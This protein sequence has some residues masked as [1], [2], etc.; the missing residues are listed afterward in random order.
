MFVN[1]KNKMKCQRGFTL[2]ELLVVIAIIGVLAAIAVPKYVNSIASANT[3]KVQADLS[4]IDTASQL[5][6]SN[7]GGAVPANIAALVPTYLAVAPTP[8]TGNYIIGGA[9]KNAAIAYGINGDG[10]GIATI[11]NSTYTADTFH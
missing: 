5:F 7:S 2:I 3:A 8:P 6:M 11:G 1:L 10:R 9:T 4:A